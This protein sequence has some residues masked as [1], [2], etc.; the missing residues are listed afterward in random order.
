M[1]AGGGRVSHRAGEEERWA[2]MNITLKN[3]LTSNNK[4]VSVCDSVKKKA[5]LSMH[6]DEGCRGN[7]KVV[8]RTVLPK[9]YLR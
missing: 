4:Q 5:L 8:K 9:S 3:S 7:P 1:G 6:A 2:G